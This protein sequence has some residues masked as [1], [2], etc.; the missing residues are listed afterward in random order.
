MA[1]RALVVLASLR[2][3]TQ[4]GKE[5]DPNILGRIEL[6]TTQ[7]EPVNVRALCF[8][9]L[10]Q[11]LGET[12]CTMLDP[13]T[14]TEVDSKG[15][16]TWDEEACATLPKGSPYFM[17]RSPGWNAAVQ[18]TPA[19]ESAMLCLQCCNSIV[20]EPCTSKNGKRRKCKQSEG[21]NEYWPFRCQI[22]PRPTGDAMRNMLLRDFYGYEFRFAR[23]QGN[24]AMG[25]PHYD[26]KQVVKCALPR[27]GC[28]YEY[29][30][31]VSYQEARVKRTPE[32]SIDPHPGYGDPA[33]EI[34][35]CCTDKVIQ[36][37]R[38]PAKHVESG[39]TYDARCMSSQVFERG[40]QSWINVAEAS[41]LMDM[42]VPSP[43][44]RVKFWEAAVAALRAA[45][46]AEK[47]VDVDRALCASNATT[48]TEEQALCS[49]LATKQ[50]NVEKAR[51]H[52]NLARL[53]R[54]RRDLACSSTANSFE[55]S[56]DFGWKQRD[57]FNRT[58]YESVWKSTGASGARVVRNRHRHAIE[59][60][61]RNILMST[62]V[63][64]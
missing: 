29:P 18:S 7:V 12:D 17:E 34:P 28:Q 44:G 46:E 53:H 38:G 25:V 26:D 21:V 14:C 47:A 59:R 62:Q 58:E 57:A 8:E 45:E 40:L 36:A 54:D 16:E 5:E 41:E 48:T 30:R 43:P 55:E 51:D 32:T 50:R 31:G 39:C 15:R 13:R 23:N 56:D 1:L 60:T 49:D 42:P 52:E 2:P 27:M 35:E 24:R 4:Q 64:V 20:L 11:Q 9:G 6:E 63:Q 22:P 10:G 3:T 37:G 33:Y 61:R 19:G